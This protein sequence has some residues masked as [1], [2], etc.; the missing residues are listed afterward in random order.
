[1]RRIFGLLLLALFTSPA[2]PAWAEGPPADLPSAIRRAERVVVAAVVAVE[3]AWQTNKWGDRLI[4]S[5]TR[6][7]ATEILKGRPAPGDLAVDMVGGTL[8]GLTLKV[9]HA[10]S[11][12][13]GDRVVFL[14]KRGENGVLVPT[15]HGAG[16]MKL[17]K[18]NRVTGSHLRLEDVRRAATA[19]R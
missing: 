3:P 12:S 17:T 1:M 9:S 19:A 16:V 5:R 18:D 8:G 7:R 13:P 6:V 15:D 14:L 10:S 11:V 2:L 4:V